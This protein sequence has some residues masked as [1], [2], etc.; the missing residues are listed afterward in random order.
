MKGTRQPCASLPAGAPSYALVTWPPAWPHLTQSP[1]KVRPRDAFHSKLRLFTDN[2]TR[3]DIPRDEIG[4]R[5]VTKTDRAAPPQ[6]A[7]AASRRHPARQRTKSPLSGHARL[8]P[9][10]QLLMSPPNL[11]QEYRRAP[12]PVPWLARG[13]VGQGEEESR[14]RA[15]FS[16]GWRL[17]CEADQLFPATSHTH[18]PV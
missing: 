7:C 17:A 15:R 6:P 4:K 2:K 11:L 13:N 9:V 18:D 14:G 8:P 10:P 16:C 1:P 5:E 12:P 3:T